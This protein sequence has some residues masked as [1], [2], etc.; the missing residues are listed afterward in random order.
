[1]RDGPRRKRGVTH[2]RFRIRV[3]VMRILEDHPL[4]QQV[5]KTTLAHP[6]KESLW[7]VSAKL[8]HRNLQDQF[9]RRRLRMS[10]IAYRETDK[11]SPN[12]HS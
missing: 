1:M 9:W 2:D 6:I 7:Q 3:R 5:T 10:G 4:I 12:N 8:I 11:K